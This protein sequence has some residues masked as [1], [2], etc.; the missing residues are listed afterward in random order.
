MGRQSLQTIVWRRKKKDR[1]FRTGTLASESSHRLDY[2]VPIADLLE[3]SDLF[4]VAVGSWFQL[5]VD[6][7]PVGY[8]DRPD[9]FLDG[10]STVFCFCC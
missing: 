7:D 4:A 1:R 8:Y 3:S 10:N 5:A 2:G 9:Q 6:L